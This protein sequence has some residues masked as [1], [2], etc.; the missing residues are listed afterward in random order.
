MCLCHFVPLCLPERSEGD[1]MISLTDVYK[2]FGDNKVLDGFNLEV[3]K[4][5]TL[6][7]IGQSGIGKSVLLKLII[8]LFT[9]EKGRIVIDGT[10]ITGLGENDLNRLRR[11]FGM[12]FQSSALLNSLSV[13]EN[14]GLPL[15]EHTCLSKE[16]I[17]RLV[18]EKLKLVGLEKVEGM[19]PADLSGGMK[20]RVGLARAIIRN[21]E[22]ILYDEPTT[23][24]DPV[25]AG[26]INELVLTLEAKLKITSL[27]VT[28]DMASAYKIAKRIAMI[29]DGRIIEIGTPEQIK[30]TENPVVRRFI[31]GGK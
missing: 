27:A 10:D 24:L 7:I 1:I 28:H 26:T 18:K 14:V 23:G 3:E 4:G 19:K 21:P 11:K 25:V 2:S 17:S 15:K 9:P 16:E 22:I 29:H 31:S 30:N 5:E 12:L 6:V 13:E 8:G 20:K